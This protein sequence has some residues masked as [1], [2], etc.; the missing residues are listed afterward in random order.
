M[1]ADRMEG[2]RR[3]ADPYQRPPDPPPSAALRRSTGRDRA[4]W[5]AVLD[6][7]GAA[8][9]EYREIADWLTGEH[10]VS[11]WWAQKLIV[12]YQQTRGQRAPGVRPDGT[13][14]AGAS[15]TVP[16]PVE[17]LFD[18]FEDADLRA[19]W[20]PGVVLHERTSQPG[21]SVRFDWGDGPTRVSA[22]FLAMGDARS[23][24]AVEHD[25]LPNSDAA[26]ARKVFWRERLAAL[27]AMLEG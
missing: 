1:K 17:R 3:S 14:A 23:Q 5:F 2:T 20:L 16:V 25:H 15:K 13:F 11:D 10:G 9:R 4:E 27:K 12:E 21:R 7:W 26:E 19:R 6:A 24:V 18:A 8:S 22:T